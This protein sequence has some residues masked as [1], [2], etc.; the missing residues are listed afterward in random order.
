MRILNPSNDYVF[1]ILFKDPGDERRLGQVLVNLLGNA[2]KFT[3]DRGSI[4]LDVRADPGRG[5]VLLTITDT[6][7]GIAA[8]DFERIF[9]P[10][11]QLDARLARE[12]AGAGLGLSVARRIVDLHGGTI[13]VE[14]ESCTSAM[15]IRKAS[16]LPPA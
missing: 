16:V 4:G 14:N 9:L 5:V 1:K 15:R 12:H 6:G 8:E 11:V 7:C 10:F 3:P 13:S 2:V